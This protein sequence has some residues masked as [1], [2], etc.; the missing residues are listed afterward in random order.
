MVG[1]FRKMGTLVVG[2]EELGTAR[3]FG[4]KD[5][6]ERGEMPDDKAQLNQLVRKSHFGCCSHQNMTL[7]NVMNSTYM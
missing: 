4:K 6:I 1:A 5:K 2:R 7:R 3:N